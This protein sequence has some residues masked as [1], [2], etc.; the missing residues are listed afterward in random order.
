MPTIEISKKDLEKLAGRKL[1]NLADELENAKAELENQDGDVLKLDIKD[2]NRPDLWSVEGIARQLSKDK[3]CPNYKVKKSKYVLDVSK[4]VNRV[5]PRIAAA[6]VKGIKVTDDLIREL[7][8]LQE[9]VALTFGRKRKEAAIGVYD[10]DKITWPVLYTTVSPHGI[11]FVA[12]D[13]TAAMTPLQIMAKHPKGREF[14]YLVEGYEEFPLI[15]DRAEQVLSMP[16][17]INSNHT[18]KVTEKTKN[19][20]VE[21]TGYDDK[22]VQASLNVMAAALADRGGKLEEVTINYDNKEIIETPNLAPKK[23]KVKI[24]TI[25]K[26]AGEDLKPKEIISLLRKARYNAK[27]VGKLIEVEYPA[28]RQDILHEVDIVEDVLIAYGYNNFEPEVPKLAV[29]G[30]ETELEKFSRKVR[31]IM[32]GFGA[33][34]VATFTLTNKDNLFKKMNITEREFE[35]AVEIENP[36][37]S[38]WSCLRNWLLPS[39]MDFLSKNTTKE[40]PQR[41]FEVGEIV[42]INPKAETKTDTLKRLAFAFSN[43][44]VTFTNAKQTLE[45][46]GICLGIKFTVKESEHSSFIAGRVGEIRA[47]GEIVGVIGELHPRVLEGFGLSVPVVGFE[48]ELNKIL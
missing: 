14:A 34:E 15:I 9:K 20:M 43:L 19:L 6:I 46:L 47:K 27:Q 22:F 39:L 5:R 44:R 38:N 25:Q 36:V 11:R 16:P 26:L 45:A 7:I 28:Y 35:R 41:I 4:K 31:E 40:F 3:G 32:V 42:K 48:L 30:E 2:T 29:H 13:M 23:A 1:K 12:L 18:G 37:S 24:E 10:F 33:Q 17:I 21:V 8:Q